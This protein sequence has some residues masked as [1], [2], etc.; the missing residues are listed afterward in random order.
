MQDKDT[1]KN[2]FS[3]G[4]PHVRQVRAAA[5]IAS[6]P[7]GCDCSPEIELRRDQFGWWHQWCPLHPSR[8]KASNR[9]SPS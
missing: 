4:S 2:P 8:R 3:P 7:G 6:R 1:E 5:L 9:R